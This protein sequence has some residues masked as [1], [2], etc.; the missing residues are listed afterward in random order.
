MNE[1]NQ[2]NQPVGQPMGQP[3][4]QPM[5][6]PVGA[7]NYN[8]SKKP[9]NMTNII[10]GG[11]AF[12]VAFA[13]IFFLF[14]G[15]GKSPVGEWECTGS[16]GNATFKLTKSDIEMVTTKYGSEITLSGK[17][18]KLSSKVSSTY[19]KSGYTYTQY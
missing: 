8:G 10:V 5:G 4:G 1:N 3:V 9:N 2:F 17:Y 6:Q 13:V 7:P 11:V 12:V 15:T 18:E 14:K 19:K 16:S